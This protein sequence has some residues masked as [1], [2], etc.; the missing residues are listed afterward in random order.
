[1]EGRS[2]NAEV[3]NE[4]GKNA[5]VRLRNSGFIP[6]VLYSHGE[7]MPL[8]VNKKEFI[9]IFEGAISESVIFDLNFTDNKGEAG[10]MAFVKDY[11]VDPVS[12]EL[13]HVDLFKVTQGEQIHTHVH[14]E[15]SGSPKGVK[16][17]GVLEINE[18][19]LE[20][21]CLPRDL[22]S[23]IEVD[24][25]ELLI[26]DSIHAR[27]IKLGDNVELLSNPDSVVVSV[28]VIKAVKTPVAAEEEIVAEGQKT[29]KEASESDDGDKK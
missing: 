12:G 19:M 11:Q 22:P 15:F 1:M 26:G 4:F 16:L 6:V 18:R 9:S 14:I 27:D 13:I 2:L 5:N 7:S 24:V 28:H 23:K 20:I 21:K 29:G 3:R 25:T 17:G 8:K 10:Q